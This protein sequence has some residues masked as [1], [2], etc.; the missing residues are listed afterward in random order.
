L[1]GKPERDWGLFNERSRARSLCRH[2]DAFAILSLAPERALS[3]DSALPTPEPLARVGVRVTVRRA[4]L[5]ATDVGQETLPAPT[6]G[7]AG[8]VL[9]QL[10]MSRTRGFNGIGPSCSAH[11]A[12]ADDETETQPLDCP[13][14]P[15]GP[16]GEHRGQ[17][18]GR[19]AWLRPRRST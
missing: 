10:R 1:Y 8:I 6:R 11:V 4:V 3:A 12:A 2:L 16:E 9:P 18:A 19:L 5:E 15:E 13:I 17:S 7:M 14:V